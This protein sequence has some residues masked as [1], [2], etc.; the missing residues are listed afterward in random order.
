MLKRAPILTWTVWAAVIVVSICRAP[1]R[2]LGKWEGVDP[3][4]RE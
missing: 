2:D 1:A 3:V 4:H